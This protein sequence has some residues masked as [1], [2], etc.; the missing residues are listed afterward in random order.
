MEGPFLSF[1]QNVRPR[2]VDVDEGDEQDRGRYFRPTD[3]VGGKLRKRCDFGATSLS[4]ATRA[5][6]GFDGL[7]DRVNRL[8]DDVFC[9]GFQRLC[10]VKSEL[11]M[12]TNRPDPC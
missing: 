3:H 4:P 10:S 8:M 5:A 6:G 9:C 12:G 11:K 1:D 7:V 2:A